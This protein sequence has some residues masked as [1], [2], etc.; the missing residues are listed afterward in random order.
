MQGEVKVGR[1]EAAL[2]VSKR[3]P[4][5]VSELG[6]VFST[7]FG[8]VYGFLGAAGVDP[9]GPP[10]VIYH[11]MPVGDD[12]MDVEICAPVGRAVDPPSGWRMQELPAGEFA[13]LV[14]V[15]PYDTIAVAYGSMTSWLDE[16]GYAPAGPPRE[17]YLSGPETPQDEIRTVIE[18]PVAASRQPAATT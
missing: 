14:H 16:H 10:F 1:R 15:G 12:P 2:V 5:R 3:L 9:E 4:A 8:E 18:F 17:V 7:A 6:G 11:E 13:T